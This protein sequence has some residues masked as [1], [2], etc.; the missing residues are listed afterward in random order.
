MLFS[1]QFESTVDKKIK[2]TITP[3]LNFHGCI[4]EIEHRINK[5]LKEISVTNLVI[6]EVALKKDKADITALQRH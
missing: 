3:F 1:N 4:N 5:R 2:T 6:F